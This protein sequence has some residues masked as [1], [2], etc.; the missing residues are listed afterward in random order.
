MFKPIHDEVVWRH[1]KA[2]RSDLFGYLSSLDESHWSQS[3]LCQGWQVRDVVAHMTILY[4]YPLS[5]V[6]VELARSGFNVNK[7]LYKTATKNGRQDHRILLKNY[8]TIIEHTQVPFFVP[9]LNALVDTLVHEQDIRI[10]LGHHKRIP[11]DVLQL[12]FKHWEPRRYNVGEKLTG[13]KKRAKGLKFIASDMDI[14]FGNG[15]VIEG[16]AQDILLGL[17]GRMP[18]INNLYGEGVEILKL[19]MT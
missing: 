5:E 10:P 6:A 7:F 14:T 4:N 1:V 16:C 8:Q 19:R 2:A 11:T 18:A 12:I 3:T 13:I 17:V 15:N 9:A